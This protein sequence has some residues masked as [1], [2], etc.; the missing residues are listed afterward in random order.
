MLMRGKSLRERSDRFDERAPPQMARPC[1]CAASL[2]LVGDGLISLRRS[3]TCFRGRR[4]LN[5][6]AVE[7]RQVGDL[8]R[9]S[10]AEPRRT[11]HLKSCRASAWQSHAEWF[12]DK[13]LPLPDVN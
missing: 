5:L 1:R 4:P 2:R 7:S 11:V 9:I 3:P 6:G 13:P 10:M 12:T 8:P